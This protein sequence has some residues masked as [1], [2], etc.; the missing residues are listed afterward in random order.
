MATTTSAYDAIVV[1]GG[2][3]GLVPRR[4]PGEGR[5]CGRSSSRRAT[6][7]GGAADTDGAGAGRPGAD[8]RP[9]RRAA[10][11]SV[12]RDLDLQ[13][14]GL[15]LVA[16]EVRVFAPQPDG[17]AV[18]AVGR[19]R[20]R[21]STASAPWSAHDADAL[22]RAS[23][24]RSARSA[25]SSPTSATR[26]RRTSR[27]P[28]FGDALAGLRLGRAFRGLGKRDG[29]TILRVLADGG[30][31]L[32]RRVVRDRRR[33]GRPLAWRGVRY[34]AMGP[35]SAGTTAGAARRRG[36]QRRRGGRAR[37]SSPRAARAR[38]P[39]RWR[40]PPGPPA[41]RSAPAREVAA[42][43]S[44]DGAVTG[45]ALASGEEIA[46]PAVVV[47]ARP[48]AAARPASSTRST[49][50]RRMRW[51][52]GNIR[53]PGVVA[54][55]NLVLDGLPRVPGRRRRRRGCSAAGSVVAPGIDAMER[56]FDAVEVR[57]RRRRRR[58]SRR[59]SR[60]SWTRRSSPARP[61]GTQVM[62]VLVQ[63]APY[64]SARR[65]LGRR[66]AS[67]LG[68]RSSRT[69]ETRRA[70]ARRAGHRAPGADAAR[71]RARVRPDRRPPAPRRARPRLVLP[72]AAAPR[73]TPA[74][75]CR[76]TGSTSPAPA[77]IPAA[78]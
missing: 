38:W 20:R 1:G 73:A 77:R 67:A 66:A 4:L 57:P 8:A 7:V 2:H 26:R 40:P 50:G 35:W 61:T 54:K 78:A 47:G 32:R 18:D 48:E 9:H 62:S 41:P 14:H 23:T 64:A 33:S 12:V 56:A 55:V 24:G 13:R 36:R 46:A 44:R 19:P 52:A 5:R 10:A 65:R 76:S 27:R 30:R 16:P 63:Y 69:L 42:I 17:R 71:P 58:S 31:R 60:R 39:R 37:R 22:R 21:P 3:N 51:R 68:D 6:G 74:T 45:V 34:T 53:T 11:A 28:G 72:V 25:G 43:T 49:S 75:G 59:R 29:R 15:S 70:R